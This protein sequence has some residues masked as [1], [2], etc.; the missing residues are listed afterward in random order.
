MHNY[1]YACNVDSSIIQV[2]ISDCRYKH[3]RH[4]LNDHSPHTRKVE[5][6]HTLSLIYFHLFCNFRVN[7]LKLAAQADE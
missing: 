4:Y 7:A 5:C 1:N 2:Q 6:E 3:E